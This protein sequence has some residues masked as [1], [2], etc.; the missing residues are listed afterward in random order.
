VVERLPEPDAEGR[1]AR[2]TVEVRPDFA[3]DQ[4]LSPF[5]LAALDL[6]D[7]E[8]PTYALDVLSV[9]EA[10]LDDPR[11][12]LKA[13]RNKARGEA[14]GEMKARGLEYEER[15]E[16]LEEITY[17][18]P[19]AELLHGAYEVFAQTQPWVQDFALSPK[20]VARD[21]AERHMTFVEYVGFYGLA[22]SEGLVLRYL[23]DAY[24]ALNRTVPDDAPH[25]GARGRRRVA[26]RARAAGRLEPAR[27]VGG[28]QAG[29]GT[30]DAV[31][32]SESRSRGR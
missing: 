30:A 20:S 12:V 32:A 25:R 7:R 14:V 29:E 4:P 16:Q 11:Q 1:R 18:Q 5:A 26:G 22:R 19:L 27:R 23:A 9:L 2:L 21:L 13:Q 15:M 3:L 10:T 6:L 17:P 31:A 8:A 28:A 24:K